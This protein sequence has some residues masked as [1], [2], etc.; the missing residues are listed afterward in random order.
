MEKQQTYMD[1]FN[2][3]RAFENPLFWSRFSVR[4][5]FHGANVLDV[6]CGWGSLCVA[7][8]FAGANKVVGLDIDSELINFATEKIENYPQLVK[9]VEFKDLD[10]R[11]YGNVEFDY[12]VSKDSFE[13]IID[14]PGMLKEMK[15]RLKPGGN[16]FRIWTPLP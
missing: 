16:F 5:D 9:I 13:H 14:M 11:F 8:A 15:K 1:I 10:L 7:I 6:G 3:G 2:R 4:P 12:I